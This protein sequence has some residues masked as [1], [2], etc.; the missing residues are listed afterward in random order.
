MRYFDLQFLLEGIFSDLSGADM[1]IGAFN[2]IAAL[3]GFMWN[4]HFEERK[5]FNS[6]A[7]VKTID[8]V[9]TSACEEMTRVQNETGIEIFTRVEPEGNK[10]K[11]S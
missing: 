9:Y 5:E 8:D 6:R 4:H 11:Q 3:S 7:L 10:E 2:M 1:K